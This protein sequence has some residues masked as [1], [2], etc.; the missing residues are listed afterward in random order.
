MTFFDLSGKINCINF[1][2]ADIGNV[3]LKMEVYVRDI[4]R[5]SSLRSETDSTDSKDRLMKELHT[6]LEKATCYLVQFFYKTGRLYSCTRTKLR[7][8][9]SIVA[10]VY[11]RNN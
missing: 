1:P 3:E 7:K 9:L 8:L 10:F 5:S 2:F 6:D 11:A 4:E